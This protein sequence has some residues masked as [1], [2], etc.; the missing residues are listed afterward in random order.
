MANIGQD[1]KRQKM[2]LVYQVVK[3]YRDGVKEIEIAEELN[4]DRRNVNN[5]LRDLEIE[6]KVYKEEYS[7]L[8]FALPYQSVKLRPIELPPEEAMTL[9][10]AVRLLVK[11]HD[12]KNDAAQLA[13][14]RLA[15]VLTKD[16]Q[17]GH[18]IYQAALELSR[19][20]GDD[21]YARIFRT[22]MQS[23]IYR[24]K[25]EITYKPLNEKSFDTIFCPYL[26][27]PS[28]VGFATYV[29]GHSSRVNDRRT[30]KLQRIQSARLTREEY[31]IP[32]DFPGLEILRNAW[33]IIHGD[34]PMTVKLR[35]SP[36]VAERVRESQW[37]P[38][39]EPIVDD[40]E[41]P[42]WILWTA[43][44][45]DLTDLIPWVRSWGSD[46]IALSPP[47]L[48]ERLTKD[49]KRMAQ[50]YGWLVHK[51]NSPEN[52][53]S[54]PVDSPFRY[55]WAKTD[56]YNRQSHITHPLICHLIDIAQVVCALWDC[57]LPEATRHYF[58]ETLQVDE[59]TARRWLAF[60]AGLH[61][62]GKA[63]AVF[64]ASCQE[65][66]KQQILS[67]LQ[68]KA[69][70]F[71]P[72]S[73]KAHLHGDM[74]TVILAELFSTQLG[75]DRLLAR[76]IAAA[77]GGH[78]GAWPS[79]GTFISVKRSTDQLGQG[80]WEEARSGLFVALAKA[81]GIENFTTLSLPQ[82]NDILN[83]FCI[84]L[85]GLTSFTD[86]MGSM[87]KDYFRFV[88][89]DENLVDYAEQ[90][91]A[92][93]RKALQELSWTNW[94]P[95]REIVPFLEL[96]DVEA[97]RP[98]QE[99]IISMVEQKE[100]TPSAL[101]IIETPMGEGKTEAAWYLADSWLAL[102][103]QQGIYVAMPTQ[104]TGNEMHKRVT[105]FIQR[106]YPGQAITPLLLHGDALWNEEMH[107]L[108]F[109][110]IG[111][112]GKKTIGAYAWFLSNK[113]RSLLS[114]FGVGTVDQALM[115]AMQTQHFFVRL[116]GLSHK[117]VIF[118]EVHAYDTYMNE[119]FQRLLSWL[120]KMGTSVILLSA[121][122]PNKT[123]RQLI[124][125]YTDDTFDKEVIYPAITWA[126][127][128]IKGEVIQVK[129]SPRPDTYLHWLEPDELIEYLRN[130][131]R[132]GGYVAIICN[133]VDRVQELYQILKDKDLVLTEDDLIVF[134]ARFPFYLRRK[135]ETLVVNRFGKIRPADQPDRAI[136]IATQVI[137]QSL[138]LDFDLMLT[139]LAPI[140]FILQRLGRLH[141][142][143]R[144]RPAPLQEPNLTI[145]KP[146]LINNLPHFGNDGKIYSRDILLRSYLAINL[147][148][149]SGAKIAIPDQMQNLIEQVYGD[150]LN[151]DNFSDDWKVALQRAKE[152]QENEELSLKAEARKRLI[153][154]PTKDELMFESSYE[155][156]D[157]D[158]GLQ[159]YLRYF[160]R[161]TRPSVTLVC[162]HQTDAGVTLDQEGKEVVDLDTLPEWD[163]AR[164]LAER[165][166]TISN[167]T[168][169]KHFREQKSH[170]AWKDHAI[171]RHYYPI[172]FRDKRYP[173]DEKLTL[174]FDEKQGIII[175]KEAK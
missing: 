109:G 89:S 166:V 154:G 13:L 165:K 172:C 122:L 77:V 30:Y 169:V 49:T 61:D 75:W 18:E 73:A 151:Q 60:L 119:L 167:P 64:Q 22:M 14:T 6:G 126:A 72:I 9:Y 112:D 108:R 81:M 113:K 144:P 137:E 138:D 124:E 155:M 50:M 163:T 128:G 65:K 52:N 114:P 37:H 146:S 10:L 86:W 160:T 161:S 145:F 139:D 148:I 175:Q 134:H 173:V 140:D 111:D 156:E 16:A 100:P 135:I 47:G 40:P 12:K 42:G 70:D 62:I 39:Q 15:E 67:I 41:K 91:Y 162:L 69:Y 2:E 164:R 59:V 101:V 121:T 74:S 19:R 116:F 3:R 93:A 133:T 170:S 94:T 118:D 90:S 95:Q 28:T 97:P 102:Y 141:R 4:I 152:K 117:T 68:N 150:E 58:A 35:F 43:Q 136:V 83:T 31:I 142:H 147:T 107:K 11:Q 34:K 130:A 26:F 7:P 45:A 85:A 127:P 1:A 8:W 149:Q 48:V 57:A 55:L 54:L 103:Q 168:V 20:P 153:S 157:E 159:E 98:L 5:Y 87:D 123:R 17:V 92:Q 131:M 84:L 66:Y 80:I 71:P 129:S 99:V 132:D 82:D 23:Y 56:K 76:K 78:H 27:E 104:A 29:I 125:A 115:A 105:K 53:D 143:E 88:A 51:D 33:S 110:E 120:A 171:L 44:V 38:S 79:N 24:R 25:V 158:E 21:A 96:F 106:R 63:T 46:V 32:P 36:Q 174:I